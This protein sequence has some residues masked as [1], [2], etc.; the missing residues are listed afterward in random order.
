MNNRTGI[1]AGSF[2][3]LHIGH[4]NVIHQAQKVFDNIEDTM[5]FVRGIVF[6]EH[7]AERHPRMKGKEDR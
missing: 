5:F 1:Y 6:P 7:V 4:L 3:P 2:S